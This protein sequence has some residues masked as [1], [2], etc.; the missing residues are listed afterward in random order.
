MLTMSDWACST[1]VAAVAVP[2]T[3]CSIGKW[4]DGQE[5]EGVLHQSLYLLAR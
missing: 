3:R 1:R 4:W 5:E 2:E